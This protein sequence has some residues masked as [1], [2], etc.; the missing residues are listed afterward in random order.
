VH[1]STISQRFALPIGVGCTSIQ[2]N[3][4]ETGALHWLRREERVEGD[5]REK[6]L[7]EDL[8]PRGAWHGGYKSTSHGMA[9]SSEGKQA[10]LIINAPVEP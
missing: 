5:L 9:A 3:W 6:S 2:G 1:L 7:E 4:Y 8:P 10:F